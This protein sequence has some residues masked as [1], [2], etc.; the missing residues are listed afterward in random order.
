[1]CFPSLS[2]LFLF[3]FSFHPFFVLIFLFHSLY[4]R[5]FPS[6]ALFFSPPLSR[7]FYFLSSLRIPFL[8]RF[9][10]ISLF[11]FLL[12]SHYFPLM[13]LAPLCPFI[14]IILSFSFVCFS[15]INITC[16]CL[17]SLTLSRLFS[18]GLTLLHVCAHRCSKPSILY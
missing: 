12:L 9:L 17:L 8:F 1:M 4:F 7:L 18:I 2:V 15:Y 13:H 6:P 11:L 10:F 3:S 16:N 14:K 5:L